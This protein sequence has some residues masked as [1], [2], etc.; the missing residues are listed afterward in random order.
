MLFLTFRLNQRSGYSGSW[1]KN[2]NTFVPYLSQVRNAFVLV[3]PNHKV[4]EV[5]QELVSNGKARVKAVHALVAIL[6]NHKDAEH[7][8][9]R[10]P[11]LIAI[12]CRTHK[13]D[14]IFLEKYV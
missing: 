10:C 12:D 13:N 11:G 9:V 8:L 3:A 7:G 1:L 4:E 6:V 14:L 2:S 5:W